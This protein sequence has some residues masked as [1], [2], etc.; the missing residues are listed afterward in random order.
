MKS[1]FPIIKI[2]LD[3]LYEQ[4]PLPSE[5]DKDEAIRAELEKLWN[6]YQKL[7]NGITINYSPLAT[8]FAY[9]YRYVGPHADVLYQLMHKI[10]VLGNAFDANSVSVSC[11]GGGPGSDFLGISKYRDERKKSTKLFCDIYDKE[12]MWSDVWTNG[13]ISDE[14]RG[15]DRTFTNYQ[16]LDVRHPKTYVQNYDLRHADLIT[17]SFFMSEVHS[18]KEQ[19]NMFFEKLF[20][21]AKK[22]SL[23]L[24]VDNTSVKAH[25]WFD[26]LIRVY[27]QSEAWNHI[28]VFA[29]SNNAPVEVSHYEKSED[30]GIYYEKFSQIGRPRR[31]VHTTY[32]FC[33]KH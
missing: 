9:Y 2:V 22:G 12:K 14:V 1:C 30:L 3:E 16:V 11:L 10:G 7:S 20:K 15:S 28:E 18:T 26:D 5:N 21:Q 19:A 13:Y 6:A 17:M 29:S 33:F 25:A 32:R 27:N 24:F 4:I 31:E 8:R 23:F